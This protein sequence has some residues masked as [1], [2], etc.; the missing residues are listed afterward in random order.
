MEFTFETAYDQKAVT[1]M[2]RALRKTQRKKRS[3]R[4]H[5]FGW[6]VIALGT[7][8]SVSDFI[9][10][11]VDAGTVI[12]L[13]TVLLLLAVFVWED[14][15]NAYIARKRTLP[16]LM[17]TSAVFTADSYRTATEMG[18]T[19]WFYPNILS[20]VEL[21]AYFVFLFSKNHAQ[22]YAKAGMTGGSAEEFCAFIAE[23]T[24]KE[25]LHIK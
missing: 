23:K 5:I 24:G 19:E 3:R 16:G 1:A 10:S 8:L 9:N 25:V 14:S 13:L 2:V 12:T 18:N 15:I 20:V 11:R 21:P 7:L 4:S 6:I 17:H 22:V